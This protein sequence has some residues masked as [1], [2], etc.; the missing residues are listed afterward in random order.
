[1]GLG[2]LIKMLLTITLTP[3][4]FELRIKSAQTVEG[5]ASVFVEGRSD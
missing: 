1:M 3:V 2:E 5:L 4:A